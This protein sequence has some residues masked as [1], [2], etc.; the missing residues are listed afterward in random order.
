MNKKVVLAYSGGLDTSVAI[1][2]L[3]EE[4]SLEVIALCIDVGQ[5]GDWEAIKNRAIAAGASEVIVTDAQE[6]FAND[7]IGPAIKSN[8][9]YEGKYPLVS[10]L[11]RPLIAKHLV[12]TARKFSADSVAHG[13][14]GK[15]NDQIRFEVA[16]TALAPELANLAPVRSWGF[17]REDAIEYAQRFD[18]PITV[19]KKSPYSIDQNLWGRAIEAGILEDPWAQPPED[20]FDLTKKTSSE[21]IEFILNFEQGIPVGID[22]VKMPL[23]Q[24]V[25]HLNKLVGS[26]GWGRIDMIENRR[27]GIKSRE[28]YEAPGALA[29]LMAHKD[30]EALNLERDLAHEKSR[31]ESIYSELIYDG[32]WYSPLKQS[33]DSFMETSQKYIN[34]QVRLRCESGTC[35]V[36]GRRSD[37][38][39]YDYTLATYDPQDAFVH[40]DAEGFVRLWGLGVQ[41][42]AKRQWNNTEKA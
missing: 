31:L 20:V 26:F 13:C 7:F 2:W 12:K 37:Q 5:G 23:Y 16:T 40:T 18:I 25:K 39:L 1:K 36:V 42:W 6:E 34:G 11:S 14:T 32:F 38:S 41:T 30:L 35:F 8:V 21:P 19:T 22:N 24:L 9:L 33:I 3:Q 27:V 17:S 29:I 28:I 15:G 10:S 4:M